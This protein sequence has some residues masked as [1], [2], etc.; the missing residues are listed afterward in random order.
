MAL[1]NSQYNA[2]MRGYEERQRLQRRAM[3][4][5]V[6][7]VYKKVPAIQEL[8]RQISSRA[9]DCARRVLGGDLNARV[10]LKEELADLREQKLALLKAA[11]FPADYMELRYDCP[12][13]QDTGYV[14]GKRCHCFERQRLNILYAQSNIESILKEENFDRLRFDFYDDTE[15]VTQLGMTERAYM[16]IVCGSAGSLQSSIRRKETAFCLP[17]V[18]ASAKH[19]LPTALQRR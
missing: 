3:E 2:V 11:G 7:E 13:C 6:E 18:P 19:F 1:S 10:H 9:A 4:A 16:E 14:N 12:D 8:D 17:A 5:R 15:K